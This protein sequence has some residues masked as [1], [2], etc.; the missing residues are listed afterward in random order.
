[1]LSRC[2]PFL[3]LA[4]ILPVL[5]GAYDDGC[6][7]TITP[8]EGDDEPGECDL[9]CEFGQKTDVEGR[10][11][12][13][14]RESDACIEIAA[15][16]HRNPETGECVDF[17]SVCDIPTGWA[18]CDGGTCVYGGAVYDEGAS[19]PA[20]DGCNECRCRADGAVI[21]T[22][23][24]CPCEGADGCGE[25]AFCEHNGE[26]YEP[27]ESFPD[28]DGCNTCFCEQGGFVS[29]TD[30]A[31]PCDPNDPTCGGSGS[32]ELDGVFY[33]DG[34]TFLAP[35]GCNS[36]SCWDGLIACTAMACEPPPPPP[37][38]APNAD[39]TCGGL[40]DGPVYCDALPP[41]CPEGQVPSIQNGCWGE[42]V[43]FEACF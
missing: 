16:P 9:A 35:D 17:P 42:C 23:M 11:Y 5:A 32:C 36:C 19:F 21:C 6:V 37:C 39:G 41:E 1:M 33:E 22:E 38:E 20:G 18:A 25:P 26:R 13:E 24:A 40:C 29:C 8:I 43:P 27:G 31:C 2:R 10:E 14:C 3:L 4:L 34:A 7:I 15:P 28:A 12:C 30:R